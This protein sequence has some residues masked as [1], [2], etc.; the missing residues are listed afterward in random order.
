MKG[1]SA[2]A[3]V[4]GNL[5][6]NRIYKLMKVLILANNIG[7]LISFR[8]EVVEAILKIGHEVTISAPHDDRMKELEA[9]G[10]KCVD[11]KISRRS[12]NPVKDFLLMIN[13]VKLIKKEKSN[14]VLSYTIK[15]NVYGGMAAV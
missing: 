1:I 11:T 9:I 15:P 10:A 4:A 8:K 7:G 5:V 13:Y 12:T 14:L 6:G 2:N 3:V